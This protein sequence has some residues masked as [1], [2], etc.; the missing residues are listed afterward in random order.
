M[1]E[2]LG[3]EGPRYLWLCLA[4]ERFLLCIF[5]GTYYLISLETPVQRSHPHSLPFPFPFLRI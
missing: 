1:V 4:R 5:H 3:C 2:C